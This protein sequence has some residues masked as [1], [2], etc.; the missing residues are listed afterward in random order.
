MKPSES[1]C[2]IYLADV[3]PLASSALFDGCYAK[4]PAARK[5]KIDRLRA[6]EA[7]RLSLG[8]GML[9]DLALRSVGIDFSQAVFSEGRY[10]KPELP[11]APEL[12]FNLSHS[13]S[14]ALCVLSN[15]PCGADVERVGRGSM[16]L[17]RR[18]FAQDEIAALEA[19]ERSAGEEG[20][21]QL[22]AR[23][24]TRKESLL[25][26]TGEGLS[27]PLGSFSVLAADPTR[28]FLEEPLPEGYATCVCLLSPARGESP[29]RC[30]PEPVRIPVNLP[31]VLSET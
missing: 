26:A 19:A 27:R 3:S 16:K 9:L 6:A 17:A 2:R 10:G 7:R 22:F 11:D 12:R 5:Q 13:G 25:K 15:L 24:W 28:L 23:V 21:Q 20:F 4:M 18:F 31:D 14:V 29:A 30:W 8:A 1:F